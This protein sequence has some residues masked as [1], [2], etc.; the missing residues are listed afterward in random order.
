MKDIEHYCLNFLSLCFLDYKVKAWDRIK[1][2]D[3]C[4]KD[5]WNGIREGSLSYT[6]FPNFQNNCG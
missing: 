6:S 4:G 3:I 5:A 1:W 2:D